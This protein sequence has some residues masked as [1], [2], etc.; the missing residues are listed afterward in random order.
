MACC[1]SAAVKEDGQGGQ[2][3]LAAARRTIG[4]CSSG[5]LVQQ[6]VKSFRGGDGCSADKVFT[7]MS[8]TGLVEQPVLGHGGNAQVAFFPEFHFFFV[9][10]VNLDHLQLRSM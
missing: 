4:L 8:H 9:A 10:G 5:S 2:I 1:L 6:R 3:L 7:D